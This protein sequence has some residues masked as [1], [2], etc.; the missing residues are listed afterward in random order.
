M[1]PFHKHKRSTLVLSLILSTILFLTQCIN[2]DNKS[3]KKNG[4]TVDSY[5]QKINFGQFAGSASCANCHNDIYEKHILTGHYLTSRAA[6]EEYIKGSFEKGKNTFP[7]HPG[8]YVE[9]EKRDSG[10]FQVAY[11]NDIEKVARRF[12]IV[13][14]SGAKGQTFLSWQGNSLFQ[15]P[16]TYFTATN[17]W[18]NSPGYPDKVIFNRPIT[19]RCLECHSTY[20]TTL[21]Q[22]PKQPESF[23]RNQIIY[24]VDCEKCH[25]PAAEHVKY[26]SENPAATA[27]KFIVNPAQLSRQ[28]QLDLCALCHGGRLNK[29][30]PSFEFT[31]GDKL[32]DYFVKDTISPDTKII[33]VHGNQYGLL[34]E[35]K[36]FIKSA[37]LTCATCHNSHENERGKT[38]LFSQRCM[39]CHS[40]EHGTF[41]KIKSLP[42]STLKTGCIDC[43]MPK[44]SSMSIAVLLPEAELPTPASI[45]THLIKVYSEETKKFINRKKSHKINKNN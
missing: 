32:A 41:C 25:G 38:T 22:Q 18:C 8:L 3:G 34:S 40:E 10:L 20:A 11:S 13:M 45:H 30:T 36:C 17:Q 37:T 1:F 27:A 44:Q 12:D 16:I 35:S 9:M 4:E 28:Q 31:A 26:Q 24:G 33:D 29:T 21:A 14:G 19:S 5:E 2:N 43:H 39:S 15:L 42:A 6:F 7:F 23:S